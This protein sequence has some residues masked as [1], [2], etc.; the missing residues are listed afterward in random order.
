VAWGKEKEGR[1]K[2][3]PYSAARPLTAAAAKVRFTKTELEIT[4]QRSS[5]S[6][7]WQ[8][9]AWRVYDNVGE[10]RYGFNLVAALMSRLRVH[11]A[12]V[13]NADEP[14]V[15]IGDASTLRDADGAVLAGHQTGID[16]RLAERARELVGQL[17]TGAGLPA[18]QRA[19]AL[20]DQ[21]AG[22]C[23]LACIDNQWSIRS[24]F[25]LKVD[26]AG[27]VLLQPS[28]STSALAPRRLSRD[29]PVARF[30]TQH[31]MYSAD[32]DCSLRSVLADCEELILLSRMS[33]NTIRSRMNAGLLYVPPAILEAS[34]TPGAEGNVDQPGAE[35]QY[36]FLTDLMTTMTQPVMDDQHG[37]AVVP[38]VFTGPE[39]ESG[40]SGVQWISMARDI[41]EHLAARAETVLT[42]VLN[43]LDLPKDAITGYHQVRF[44]NGQLV[45]QNLY[46]Q[47]VEPKALSWVDGLTKVFLQPLLR[48]DAEVHGWDPE[49][50][51]KVVIWYDPS[52]IVTRPDRGADADAGFDRGALSDDAWRRE[53]GFSASDAPSDE[54]LIQR[55][56]TSKTQ[57]PPNLIDYVAREV[58]PTFFKSAPSLVTQAQAGMAGDK[59]ATIPLGPTPPAALPAAEPPGGTLP[60][61]TAS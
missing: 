43:G 19:Y 38:M 59:A 12:V 24:N 53:H 15:E 21:V 37:A 45:D 27:T 26:A 55:M 49:Q 23:Y 50:V 29:T 31:P 1:A 25:E 32:P 60:P 20:N 13:V 36:P 30:W 42:R 16:P 40:G 46:K 4:R 61:R 57:L 14:P 7:L 41:D 9:E 34:R 47:A 5:M 52:E 22:E 33:R 6:H 11:A 58:F 17:D 51:A 28:L 18:M 39:A 56:L 44:S 8:G 35:E 2:P 48:A 3:A 54:E 10:V